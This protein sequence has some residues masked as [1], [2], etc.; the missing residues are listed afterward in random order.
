MERAMDALDAAVRSRAIHGVD[1]YVVSMGKVVIVPD[2][3][4]PDGPMVPLIEKQYSDA[5][6]AL[7]LKGRRP[8]GVQGSR[9][10]GT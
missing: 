7:L 3:S 10:A 4:H 5:L 6:A 8:E 9:R 1:K 2:P